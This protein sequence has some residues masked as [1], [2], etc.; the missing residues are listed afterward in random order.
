MIS[1]I[2]AVLVVSEQIS[3]I[4]NTQLLFI[5]TV[6]RNGLCPE[7]KS[8]VLVTFGTSREV[9]G[10][11][12]EI[13]QKSSEMT[14]SS[15]DSAS[16]Y[17]DAAPITLGP[18]ET[19]CF[20]VSLDGVPGT[21][22]RNEKCVFEIQC[23]FP[24]VISGTSS[25]NASTAITISGSSNESIVSV[26]AVAGIAVALSLLVVLPVGVVFGCCGMWC[27]MK[28]RGRKKRRMAPPLY[29]EPVKP[30]FSLTEN[31]AY[32]QVARRQ[33]TS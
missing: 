23:F 19:I 11:E 10:G 33:T 15:G 8:P 6:R 12:C 27:L 22:H 18:D 30:V 16:F 31:Q 5:V 4:L 32:G 21:F 25:R 14:I 7:T 13:Q 9:A 3:L 2:V 29:E 17:G 24:T 26:D 28:S 20:I 1:P